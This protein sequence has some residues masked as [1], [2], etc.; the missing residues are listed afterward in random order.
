LVSP[1]SAAVMNSFCAWS[2]FFWLKSFKALS[3]LARA[4][5]AMAA[6]DKIKA[7]QTFF[8]GIAAP[9]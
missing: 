1:V 9:S 8:M 2:N 6:Q 5:G 3:L 4:V 7:K